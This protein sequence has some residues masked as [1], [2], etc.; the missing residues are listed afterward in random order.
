VTKD[1]GDS[2]CARGGAAERTGK[3]EHMV[4]TGLCPPGRFVIQLN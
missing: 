2:N 1:S 4:S 3:S